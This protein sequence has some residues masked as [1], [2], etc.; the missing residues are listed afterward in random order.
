MIKKDT[1][2]AEQTSIISFEPLSL[3][4]LQIVAD[5]IVARMEAFRPEFAGL[6]RLQRAAGTRI[7][8]LFHP[9]RWEVKSNSV[10]HLQPQKGNALRVLNFV[11]IGFSDAAEFAP[12]LADI[13][14]LPLR[15]YERAFSKIVS[16]VGLWR[17][18]NNGYMHPSSH[19]LRHIKIKQLAADGDSLEF[20]ATWIGE[21]NI[22]NL[23]YYLNSS[24]FL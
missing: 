21:K 16:D 19:M 20:I 1:I 14:R 11:D 7:A 10:V 13:G 24:F 5:D 18:Y 2:P 8:E 15:Q 3:F 12:I 23:D 4:Q 22:Q 17:L 9:Q 6:I